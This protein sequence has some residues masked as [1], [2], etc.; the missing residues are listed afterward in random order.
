MTKPK[1]EL[2]ADWCAARGTSAEAE[3]AAWEAYQTAVKA[4]KDAKGPIGP[5]APPNTHA[6]TAQKVKR[7]K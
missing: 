6:V 4:E 7:T 1:D 2:Y 3:R 5:A